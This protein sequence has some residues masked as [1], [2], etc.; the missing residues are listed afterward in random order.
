M[1]MGNQTWYSISRINAW[2]SSTR[3]GS[4]DQLN[5]EKSKGSRSAYEGKP[6]G[7]GSYSSYQE[8]RVTTWQTD[9]KT[10]ST[11]SYNGW[12]TS[13]MINRQMLY[14]RRTR[15]HRKARLNQRSPRPFTCILCASPSRRNQQTSRW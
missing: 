2:C 12:T 13:T 5:P 4:F 14:Q 8:K 1:A 7:N 11:L 9:C 15:N 6:G 10:T 3:T